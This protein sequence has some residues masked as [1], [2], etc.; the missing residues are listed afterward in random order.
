MR[1]ASPI[2]IAQSF[3]VAFRSGARRAV[4]AF[5]TGGAVLLIYLALGGHGECC[6][7]LP[8]EPQH[9][10]TLH[11][12]NRGR[13]TRVARK[14]VNQSEGVLNLSTVHELAWVVDSC[15]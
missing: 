1:R 12:P 11:R 10:P 9:Q 8:V 6:D 4:G 5:L 15:C 13:E 7:A 2:G 14:F 3:S